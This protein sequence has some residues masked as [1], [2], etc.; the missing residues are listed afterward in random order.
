ML[1]SVNKISDTFVDSEGR[2]KQ[3][4]ELSRQRMDAAAKELEDLSRRME[5]VER[6][7][8]ERAVVS[9]GSPEGSRPE[10]GVGQLSWKGQAEVQLPV[11]RGTEDFRVPVL[12]LSVEMIM[13]VYANTPILLEPFSRACSL[14]GRTLSGEI[15]EVELEVF[16]QGS[17]WVVESQ[18][19]GWLLVPRPGSLDRKTSLQSLERLYT[20]DGVRQLPVLLHLIQPAKLNAVEVGKRWQ[21]KERGQLNVSPDPLRVGLSER[22]A[23]MEQRLAQIENQIRS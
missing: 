16:A 4:A 3:D 13:E 17:T 19:G 15:D 20:I 7:L 22:M 18:A 8:E 5:W 1:N 14:T 2:I 12:N 10:G 11:V 23:V 6:V 9:S 21:L